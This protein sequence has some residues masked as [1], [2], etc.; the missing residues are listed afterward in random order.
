MLLKTLNK[1]F[2]Y[3]YLLFFFT[4]VNAG[5]NELNKGNS[6]FICQINDSAKWYASRDLSKL[7]IYSELLIKSGKSLSDTI[8]LIKGYKW[9]S[10]YYLLHEESLDS[11]SFYKHLILNI[12]SE[13][14]QPD[15][16][17]YYYLYKTTSAPGTKLENTKQKIELLNKAFFYSILSKN[18]DIQ[19]EVLDR[20]AHE[21]WQLGY[22]TGDTL[23]YR[24]AVKFWRLAQKKY[25]LTNDS[26]KIL[27]IESNIAI[28][29]ISLGL[30]KKAE[31]MLWEAYLGYQKKQNLM[32]MA[33]CLMNIGESKRTYDKNQLFGLNLIYKAELLFKKIG[34]KGGY[35]WC[36]Q[37]LE[38][39]YQKIGYYK[40]AYEYAVL[41]YKVLMNLYE[42][43]NSRETYKIRKLFEENQIKKK[44]YKLKAKALLAE[45][46]KKNLEYLKIIL[47]GIIILMILS[48]SMY[49]NYSKKKREK[50]AIISLLKGQEMERKR[51]AS[52][53]H[54][55]LGG[56]LAAI[57]INAQLDKTIVSNRE[58]E[59]LL[60]I[61]DQAA[62]ELRNITHNL[63]PALI[64]EFG[65]KNAITYFIELLNKN[66]ETK[67]FFD[68]AYNGK[69][70]SEEA[71]IQIYRII[72]E[73]LKN[74]LTHARAKE[75]SLQI[76]DDEKYF[77]L[78]IEDDGI[79]IN[80]LENKT[81]M[82]LN[83]M[84]S[85]A[86]LLEG[87]MKIEGYSHRGT[88]IIFT[89]TISKLI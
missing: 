42:D 29:Y 18:S 71:C 59:K 33:S 88:T 58:N 26:Q 65:L 34:Y 81:G 9:K 15:L 76:F 64:R 32:G 70:L 13:K 60:K 68:F 23:N 49:W 54:D 51:L 37:L 43:R 66:H 52:D 80:H 1:I 78:I 63:S 28:S 24:K 62:D 30:F 45:K 50:I 16:K 87:K 27:N 5:S 22:D 46:E 61:I 14:N 53:L 67:C 20:L 36:Y 73:G 83:T 38:D 85:R 4:K 57:K 10:Q 31:K 82:G 8:A 55:G 48:I 56:M 69:S 44:E 72:T 86:D 7:K 77:Y 35:G 74:A 40:K 41:R 3:F 47:I 12:V 75:I 21:W 2:L 79:G 11:V 6:Y 89:F 84:K 17:A 25:A 39:G 19:G